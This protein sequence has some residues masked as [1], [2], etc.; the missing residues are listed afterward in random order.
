MMFHILKYGQLKLHITG[1][2]YIGQTMCRTQGMIAG[3]SAIT[4]RRSKEANPS[5]FAEQENLSQKVHSGHPL[6]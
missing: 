6:T 4:S 1:S 3:D 5:V 2:V